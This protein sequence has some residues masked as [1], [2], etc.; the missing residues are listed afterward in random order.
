MS[1]PVP[2]RN[3][4]P[5]EFLNKAGEIDRVVV[6][7]TRKKYYE[8]VKDTILRSMYEYS[9]AMLSCL[10]RAD[11]LYATEQRGA[12]VNELLTLPMVQERFRLFNEA[13]GYLASLSEKATELYIVKPVKHRYRGTKKRL[14]IL[15]NIEYNLIKGCC[16]KERER[17]KK[18]A[19]AN[20]Q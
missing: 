14:G 18:Y 8:D 15:M 9:S 12:A 6:S 7:L 17:I 5:A 13:K 16:D 4:S 2:K 20:S 11:D 19:K 3:D 10:V 1:V